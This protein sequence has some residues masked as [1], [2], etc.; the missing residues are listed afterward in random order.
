MGSLFSSNVPFITL[1]L[2]CSTKDKIAMMEAKLRQMESSKPKP[3]SGPSSATD[4]RTNSSTS[5][6]S[7]LPTKPPPALPENH[8][9][10]QLQVRH[11][12][13]VKPTLPSLPILPPSQSTRTQSSDPKIT[14][15]RQPK[16]SKLTGVKIGKSKEKQVAPDVS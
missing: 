16:S 5:H 14:A 7:S 1:N 9:P 10:K 8:V 3:T 11:T 12:P 2:R 15:L 6:H 4:A 13:K